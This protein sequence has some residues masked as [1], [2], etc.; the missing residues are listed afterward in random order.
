MSKSLAI[1]EMRNETAVRYHYTSTEIANIIDNISLEVIPFLF[2]NVV[3][4]ITSH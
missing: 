3:V 1:K 2:L 4:K